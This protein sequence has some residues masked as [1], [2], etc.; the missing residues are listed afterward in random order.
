MGVDEGG[1]RRD[2]FRSLLSDIF[3]SDRGLFKV[4]A[5]GCAYAVNPQ[6]HIEEN[7]LALFEFAGRI[8]ARAVIE[9]FPV[10]VCLCRALLKH[11]L[12]VSVTMRDME[13]TDARMFAS[14]TQ[15]RTCEDPS[16]AGLCF[17]IEYEEW[18]ERK[19]YLL[20]PNGGDI[21]VTAENVDEYIALMVDYK[22][23]GE[24][25]QQLNAFLRGFHSLIGK[26]EIAMFRP[27]ELGM[28]IS[29]VQEIDPDEFEEHVEY[30]GEYSRNHEVIRMFFDVFRELSNE[31]KGKILAFVTG[32]CRVPAEGFASYEWSGHP[33]TIHPHGSPDHMPHA[34][35]CFRRL[36]LPPYQTKEIM[37]EKLL[38]A[39]N[40]DSDGFFLI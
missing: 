33:F 39:L 22:L 13:D 35:T 4:V 14:L 26:K 8:M 34:Q 17:E 37:K 23:E 36:G 16:A 32:A 38:L 2:W 11:L 3:R 40:M 27:E 6:S 30:E 7:H 1:L 5:N 28:L 15:I 20:K 25:A 24:C 31:E 21:E 10:G 9:L 18:G 12:G 29:G 19:S